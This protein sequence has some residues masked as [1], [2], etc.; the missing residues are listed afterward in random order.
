MKNGLHKK[1]DQENAEK[2]VDVL[3]DFLENHTEFEVNVW[4]A[5]MFNTVAGSFHIS[6]ASY[7]DFKEEMQEMIKFYKHIWE[8]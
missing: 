3:M 5:A 1:E 2:A 8:Q 6:G 4:C 7:E